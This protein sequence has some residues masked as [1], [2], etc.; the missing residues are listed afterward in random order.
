M[1]LKSLKYLLLYLI[2]ALLTVHVL[3]QKYHLLKFSTLN[4]V[5]QTVQRPHFSKKGWIAGEYQDQMQKFTEDSFALRPPLIR[6]YNQTDFSL[7]S[8]SHA[9]K[10]TVGKDGYLFG[11][12]YIE[13]Y[14][15][16][17]FAG[18]AACENHIRMMKQLQ[19]KLWREKKILFLVIF[20]PDKATFF[21][22]K[23][24]ARYFHHKTNVSNYA[25][26]SRRCGEEGINMIDFNS[27]FLK[28]KDTCRF[29]LY[30]KTGIHWSSYGAMLTADS[31]IRYLEDRLPAKLPRLVVDSIEM[32]R[33]ARDEDNDIGWTMNLMC[34][35]SHP[36]YAYPKFH[37]ES[38]S[39]VQ[40]PA[41]L[42]IGDS[43]YWNWYKGGYIRNI[44]SN[45]DFWYYNKDVYPQSS[46]TPYSTDQ[47]S[48]PEE[49]SKQKVIILIQTNAAYGNPGYGFVERALEELDGNRGQVISLIKKIKNSPEWLKVIEAKAKARNIP[50]EEMIRLDAQ[51]M[52]DQ[53]SSKK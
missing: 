21:P 14:L 10:I 45:E 18:I 37:F 9:G 29:P 30:P 13:S 20:T 26:Y 5:Y 52:A 35:I 16:Y 47:V 2:F 33:H 3:Q 27:W 42:F 40:K 6:L 15:G 41:A 31:L 7:F 38:D 51:F 22:E 1:M 36:V 34:G 19:D 17:N 23:I 44:F 11:D 53:Q 25:Y 4:G 32:D 46:Q 24:P 28:L 43:F 50:V 48:L 12:Q 49:I 8:L 39:T